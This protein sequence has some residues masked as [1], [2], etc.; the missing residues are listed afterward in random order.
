MIMQ[1]GSGCRAFI[2][3]AALATDVW[4]MFGAKEYFFGRWAGERE[5]I[6]GSE[7]TYRK[8]NYIA[9]RKMGQERILEMTIG[10]KE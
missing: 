2:L 5:A 8:H 6:E 1:G 7:L 10:C 3:V 4:M 9:A